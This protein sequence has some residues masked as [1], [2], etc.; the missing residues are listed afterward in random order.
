MLLKIGEKVVWKPCQR[1]ECNICV[2][3][4]HEKESRVGIFVVKAAYREG[5]GD[6][7]VTVEPWAPSNIEF[8]VDDTFESG[9]IN[10]FYERH[11]EPIG[12]LTVDRILSELMG[13]L[14]AED[15]AQRA[16]WDAKNK[17]QMV[18]RDNL[19][20]LMNTGVIKISVNRDMLNRMMRIPMD[21]KR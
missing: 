21:K 13:S 18:M 6:V 7:L 5:D 12:G 9:N 1:E 16:L 19:K 3:N 2:E 4:S 11:L 20:E 14:E 15:A 10:R 8:H 17:T